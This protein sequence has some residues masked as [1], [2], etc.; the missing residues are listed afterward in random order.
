[1]ANRL[2]TTKY[3][4]L[5]SE[6]CADYFDK[7]V[8]RV[9]K[10]L[11]LKEENSDTIDTYIKDLLFELTGNNEVIISLKNDGSFLS[12]IG[13]IEKLQTESDIKTYRREV[14]NCIQNVTRLKRKYSERGE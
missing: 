11:P 14:F 9:Y 8:N 5:P 12:I 13:R 2:I 1:M 10:L 7:L 6:L 3:N 4:P